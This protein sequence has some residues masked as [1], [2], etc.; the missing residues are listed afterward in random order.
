L[1]PSDLEAYLH[2]HIPLSSAMGVSVSAVDSD[3]VIL[4]APLGPNINHR[5]TVFGGSASALAILA[6][7]ALVH[8]RLLEAGIACRIVI[9]RNSVEYDAPMLGDFVARSALTDPDG[10]PRFLRTLKRHGRARVSVSCVM[11]SAGLECGSFEGAFV[12]I[13]VDSRAPDSAAAGGN[14]AQG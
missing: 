3:G 5:D 4:S 12:A 7:W 13:D 8:V 1:R 9:Q 2:A 11:E 10:W 6:A 14:P